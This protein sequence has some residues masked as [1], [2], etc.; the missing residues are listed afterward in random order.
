MLL[1]PRAS[2]K[3]ACGTAF[4]L[5]KRRGVETVG[6]I[7]KANVNFC[8]S[9]VCYHRVLTYE[10]L[11]QIAR[12]TPCAFIDFAGNS[13]LRMRTHSQIANLKYSCSVGGT[14]VDLLGNNIGKKGR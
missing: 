6:L 11:D 4:R 7:S 3:T 12:D 8:E 13:A 2:S 9:L 14:H 5:A 1:V 10:Q